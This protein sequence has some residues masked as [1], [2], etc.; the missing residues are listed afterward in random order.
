MYIPLIVSCTAIHPQTYRQH[1]ASRPGSCT[2]HDT[3]GMVSSLNCTGLDQSVKFR[4]GGCDDLCGRSLTDHVRQIHELWIGPQD[5]RMTFGAAPELMQHYGAGRTSSSSRGAPPEDK[6]R[7]SIGGA[8]GPRGPL[9]SLA[10]TTIGGSSVASRAGSVQFHSAQSSKQSS[11]E[12]VSG[13][14]LTNPVAAGASERH[15]DNRVNNII[16]AGQVGARLPGPAKRASARVSA[17]RGTKAKGRGNRYPLV[18][19]YLDASDSEV[20]GKASRFNS[21]NLRSKQSSKDSSGANSGNLRSK[22]SSKDSS[23]ALVR[24][25]ENVLVPNRDENDLRGAENE[26]ATRG[27]EQ[28]L[29]KGSVEASGSAGTSGPPE[30]PSRNKPYFERPDALPKARRALNPDL[31]SLRYRPPPDDYSFFPQSS[32]KRVR[33]GRTGAASS[34][35]VGGGRV[36][37]AGGAQKRSAGAGPLAPPN[38]DH[39]N[40]ATNAVQPCA[41]HGGSSRRPPH[42]PRRPLPRYGRCTYIDKEIHPDNFHPVRSTLN[43]RPAAVVDIGPRAGIVRGGGASGGVAG[44]PTPGPGGTAVGEVR[45]PH[46]PTSAPRPLHSVGEALQTSPVVT[47]IRGGTVPSSPEPT[48]SHGAGAV[49]TAV[50]DGPPS[51]ELLGARGAAVQSYWMRGIRQQIWRQQQREREG[52]VF[53]P[54]AR[55]TEAESRLERELKLLDESLRSLGGAGGGAVGAEVREVRGQEGSSPSPGRKRGREDLSVVFEDRRGD[56]GEVDD[57]VGEDDGVGDEGEDGGEENGVGDG[58]GGE[59]NAMDGV[60]EDHGQMEE[61]GTST[62]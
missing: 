14:A 44:P 38:D 18:E 20:G 50:V 4:V 47:R 29:V 11:K 21:G 58:N 19:V 35:Y 6:S 43:P 15:A 5:K 46:Q 23:G 3:H 8:S 49:G 34:S 40:K 45:N 36:A 54:A 60:L 62:S 51:P 61:R 7:V 55:R 31:E 17:Y 37:A 9:Q 42:S 39:G 41:N 53:R 10:G 59:E 22:Q 52:V 28:G 1:T 30:A 27:G 2:Q 33:I 56:V 24:R 32:W 26:E 12:R 13:N 25:D 16:A 48:S 57:G